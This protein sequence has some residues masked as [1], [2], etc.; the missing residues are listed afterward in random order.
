MEVLLAKIIHFPDQ[1]AVIKRKTKWSNIKKTIKLTL[2]TEKLQF[3]VK[4][5]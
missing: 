5:L 3:K 1:A 2:K 4:S